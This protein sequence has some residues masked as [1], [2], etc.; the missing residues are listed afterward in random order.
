M[1][2]QVRHQ[3]HALGRA[4]AAVHALNYLYGDRSSPSPS[5]PSVGQRSA[6][7]HIWDSTVA[8]GPE[9]DEYRDDISDPNG[10][11]GEACPQGP[12]TGPALLRSPV[13]Y[14]SFPGAMVERRMLVFSPAHGRLG[15]VGVFYVPK[16]SGR[17]RVIFDTR[18]A[19]CAFTDAPRTQLPSA[20]AWGRFETGGTRV[21]VA[22]ADLDVAFYRAQ[23]P[24]GMEEYFTL[25]PIAAK[26]SAP[27]GITVAGVTGEDL[28]LPQVAVL[29]M[30]FSWA[31]HL[32][33]T[34]PQTS[35]CRAGFSPEDLVLDG[36]CGCQLSDDP[37]SVVGAGYVDN[38][39]VLGGSA[40]QVG[41]R[42]R[43]VPGDLVRHGLSVHELEA[44]SQD[45]DVL[46]LSLREGRC[47]SLRTRN[48]WRLRAASR[49][50]T[51]RQAIGGF[52]LRVLA[53][54]ITWA[55]LLRR[56]LLCHCDLAGAK[57]RVVEKWGCKIEGG[58]QAS[59]RTVGMGVDSSFAETAICSLPELRRALPAPLAL[60]AASGP[61]LLERLV[62]RGSAAR[63]HRV[64][65]N[66]FVGYCSK[67]NLDW[68]D[69]QSLNQAPVTFM[70]SQ[71]RLGGGG[72]LGNVLLAAVALF[73]GSLRKRAAMLMPR[74]RRAAATWARRASSRTRLP[75]TRR[76]V[77]AL[78][79]L[80]LRDG[81]LWLAICILV[82]FVCYLRPMEAAKRCGCHLVAPS[83]TVGAGY[84][85]LGLLQLKSG[86]E[87]KKTGIHGESILFDREPRLTPLLEALKVR[88]APSQQPFGEGVDC[89]GAL[90]GRLPTLIATSALK[91][92][93]RYAEETKLPG[94]L[95]WIHSE[96]V[97]FGAAF[98]SNLQAP[99]CSRPGQGGPPAEAVR[100]HLRRQRRRAASSSTGRGAPPLL[101]RRPALELFCGAGTI[102]SAMNAEGHAA[103][104]TWHI[105]NDMLSIFVA[106]LFF[107]L[108]KHVSVDYFGEEDGH[109]HK[110]PGMRSSLIA[111]GRFLFFFAVVHLLIYFAAKLEN[112]LWSMKSVGIVGGHV[113]GFA[114]IDVF[115]GLLEQPF[116]QSFACVFVVA[117]SRSVQWA[118]VPFLPQAAKGTWGRRGVPRGGQ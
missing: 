13:D 59:N 37:A 34:V 61:S 84:H 110:P 45:R 3:L 20:S 86:Q 109:D 103:R 52:L 82:A 77:P 87:P 68:A 117:A 90:F 88:T 83:P 18:L 73:L 57:G 118:L 46:G 8:L 39:F 42:L 72:H 19:T 97:E 98:E 71:F 93:N 26:Y 66:G 78:A 41:Q 94:E 16:R 14:A 38:Y 95:A 58:A 2:R 40:K 7:G 33:Q 27:P 43:V 108:T 111:V 4:S 64:T 101:R 75:P 63:P 54:H 17:L 31:L 107:A 76:A 104:A 99:G 1:W 51:R 100:Q 80:L 115:G 96:M 91:S 9:P 23:V 56:E 79:G 65:L 81:F 67:P 47:L 89:L 11:R 32:C 62:I 29:P 15:N 85:L 50:A 74:A 112:P 6:A 5:A 24:E 116:S 28:V 10:L 113:I 49:A 53:G 60:L 55:L 102:A 22:S 30:G 12:H 114:A 69:R 92:L 21:S 35:L 105:L 44:P 25:P 70:D 106:V 36:H 48:I